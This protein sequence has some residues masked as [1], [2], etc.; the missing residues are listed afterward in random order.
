M[1]QVLPRSV[2]VDSTYLQM[3]HPTF[4]ASI[5]TDKLSTGTRRNSIELATGVNYPLV[6]ARSGVKP[7]V[8][9]RGTGS[10]SISEE[11]ARSVL[12]A[13]MCDV[14]HRSITSDLGSCTGSV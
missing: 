14:A 4:P 3:A 9:Y 13:P 5:E 6:W 8:P 12:G 2:D 11:L 7:L 1:A 10:F